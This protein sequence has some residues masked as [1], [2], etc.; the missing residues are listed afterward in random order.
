MFI[1]FFLVS[2]QGTIEVQFRNGPIFTQYLEIAVN[3]PL[4]DIGNLLSYRIVYLIGCRVRPVIC[5]CF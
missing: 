5:Q 2:A 4:T 1:L 3:S